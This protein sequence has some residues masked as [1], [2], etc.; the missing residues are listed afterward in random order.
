MAGSCGWF[1]LGPREIHAWVERHKD[2][3]PKTLAEIARY[4]IPFRKAI[5]AA[6]EPEVRVSL[7][8]EHLAGFLS[9]ESGLTQEQQALIRETIDELPGIVGVA[10]A[11]GRERLRAF[12]KRARELFTRE[13]GGPIFATLGPLE[14][15][16]GLPIP[17]DALPPDSPG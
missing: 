15:P 2:D 5:V 4:P 13:Q 1:P 8:R 3:L 12:D 9:E 14:P 10:A 6:V 17:A 11:D 16:E 7:W